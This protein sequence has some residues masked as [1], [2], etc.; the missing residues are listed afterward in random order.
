MPFSIH[1]PEL[2]EHITTQWKFANFCEWWNGKSDDGHQAE[3]RAIIEFLLLEGCEGDD[4]MLR[5]QNGPGRDA[6]CRTSI[7]RWM[8]EICRGNEEFGNEGRPGRP[9]RRET[10]A[11]LRSILRDDPN[12][13]L[14]TLAE[15]LSISR[16][17]VRTHMSPINDTLKSL[18][19][20]P[21]ALTSESKHVFFDLG[22]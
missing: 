17:T 16:E 15:T 11:A 14:R 20:I 3:Q 2:E 9:Y 18:S 4:I 22:L 1:I 7:A 6:Y 10:D 13:P 8:N 5:L 21:R 12:A 19:W